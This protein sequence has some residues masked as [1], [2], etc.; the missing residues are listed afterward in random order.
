LA[1][2]E[3]GHKQDISDVKDFV[4]H[5]YTNAEQLR[6]TF[7][8]IEPTLVRYPAIDPMD[9]RKNVSDFIEGLTK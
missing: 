8:E 7:A 9:F 2:L 5:G 6:S 4:R 1:K 3:R